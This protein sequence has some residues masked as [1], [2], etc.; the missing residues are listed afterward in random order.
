M[1]T[2]R[3]LFAILLLAGILAM[4]AKAELNY[5]RLYMVGAATPAG[6]DNAHE[7]PE[8][9]TPIGNDCFLWDGYLEEGQLKF[10][11]TRGDWGSSLMATE[12]DLRFET[13]KNYPINYQSAND[14][15]FYNTRAGWVRVVV[16]LRNLT[17]NFRRPVLAIVGEAALGWGDPKKKVIPVFADDDGNVVWSGQLRYGEVK[18]LA[19]NCD[20]W[21]PCYNAPSKDDLLADGGHSMH[22]NHSEDYKYR[23]PSAGRYTLKFKRDNAESDFY[24]VEVA[25][26]SAPSLDGAFTGKAGRY[27]AALDLSARRVHVAPVPDRLYIGTSGSDCQEIVRVADGRFSSAVVLEA[28]Q[29]YKLSS[30]PAEWEGCALSPNTDTDISS[31]TTAN[32]APMHGYSYTVPA[33]GTYMVTADF[34]KAAPSLHAEKQTASIVPLVGADGGAVSVCAAAG[35]IV[36]EGEYA[37]LEIYDVAGRLV[38]QCSPCHVGEGIYLVKTDDNVLKISV[39]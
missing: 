3:A 13:G 20:D 27:L 36:V 22:L 31:T 5:L 23:V 9:M 35:E 11:N 2:N 25:S 28:G 26:E 30:N 10:I 7:L 17:V 34:S 19:G 33:D 16:D 4:P 39:R 15:K 29:Y 18:F 6:W 1:R 37:S 21:S 24:A 38:G 32:V 8:E 14:Y 12:D